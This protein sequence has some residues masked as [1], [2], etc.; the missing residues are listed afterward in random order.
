MMALGLIVA[1]LSTT[2]AWGARPAMLFNGAEGSL[3]TSGQDDADVTEPIVDG[4]VPQESVQPSRVAAMHNST[5]V[6]LRGHGQLIMQHEGHDRRCNCDNCRS[7]LCYQVVSGC[8]HFIGVAA[9]NAGVK[10]G[11]EDQVWAQAIAA[12]IQMVGAVSTIYVNNWLSAKYP[13]LVDQAK[14]RRLQQNQLNTIRDMRGNLELLDRQ[15][16]GEQTSRQV[17]IAK[18]QQQV[19][20]LTAQLTVAQQQ[21]Q[22]LEQMEATGCSDQVK[23]GVDQCVEMGC[24]AKQS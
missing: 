15:I 10:I 6:E 8:G 7:K 9:A 18:L 17:E 1:A 20:S 11:F 14:I 12:P 23:A 22:D 21:L 3:S 2:T 5:L 16:K 24:C 19:N 4:R 13:C